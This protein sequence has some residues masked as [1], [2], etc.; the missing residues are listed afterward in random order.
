VSANSPPAAALFVCLVVSFGM[1]TVL[2]VIQQGRT[3]A[4][5]AVAAARTTSYR[6]D[7][8][9]RVDVGQCFIGNGGEQVAVGCLFACL[10]LL[11]ALVFHHFTPF[12]H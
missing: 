2:R 11:S 5:V 8:A 10:V 7:E 12:H 3:G 1:V 9:G 6:F 4:T